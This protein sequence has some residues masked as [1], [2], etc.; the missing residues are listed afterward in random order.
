MKK[1]K[2]RY[3][4][5]TGMVSFM[6]IFSI[7]SLSI[8]YTDS[9]SMNVKADPPAG[10][11][12]RP[13]N[14]FFTSL[15]CGPCI[16]NGDPAQDEVWKDWGY[17][18]A[19]RY[20]WIVFHTDIP[21]QDDLYTS[22]GRQ[23][24]NDYNYGPTV[25]N[26]TVIYD[27]G[28]IEGNGYP[29]DESKGYIDDSG[30]RDVIRDI[31]VYIEQEFTTDGIE[32]TYQVHYL[33]GEGVTGD[34]TPTV[35]D[36]D[37][38]IYIFVVEDNVTAYSSIIG[39]N[40]LNHNVFRE[41]AREDEQVTMVED[42][43]YNSSVTWTWPS[44]E[45]TVPIQP[46]M[47][48]GIIGV[49]DREDTSSGQPAITMPRTSNSA[50]YK[51]TIWDWEED[52]PVFS[53]VQF[54]NRVSDS[55]ISADI[56]DND[57]ISS[58][59]LVYNLTGS[60]YNWNVLEMDV[61]S[62][63]YASL[64]LTETE[65][66]IVNYTI[67]AYDNNQ[68]GSQTPMDLHE[69]VF[70][71]DTSAPSVITDLA[72]DSGSN[73]GEVELTWS[74]PGD[75]G[76]SGTATRYIIK[77]ATTAITSESQW[78]SATTIANSISPK[79]SGNTETLTVGELPPGQTYYFAVRAEDEVGNLALMSNS[80]FAT[81]TSDPGDITAPVKITNLEA[82][83]GQNVGEIVLTWT[84]PG[85]DGDQGTASKYYIKH[86]T[87]EI[88]SETDWDSATDIANAPTPQSASNQESFTINGLTVDQTYYFAVR[89]EDDIPNLSD[90]S[91]SP[92]SVPYTGDLT[93]PGRIV[94]LT[95]EP[96]DNIGEVHLSWTAPNEDGDSGGK[97]TEYIIRYS[98]SKIE[99][100]SDWD[101]AYDIPDEPNPANPGILESFTITDLTAD[102]GYYFAIRS[103]DEVPNLSEIS[104]SA[105]ATAQSS[106][107]EPPEI[108]N[109]Y[110][111][112]NDPTPSDEITIYGTVTGDVNSVKLS[113][114]KV[115]ETCS[116]Q[117]MDSIGSSKYM[118]T[119][120]PLSE[121]DYEYE[122]VARDTKDQE[123]ISEVIHLTVMFSSNEDSDGDGVPDSE[124]AFPD[125]D[126]Q[127]ED[128]DNDGYGD[129]PDGNNPDA[130]P[131]D[132]DR[133]ITPKTEEDTP[134]YESD[135]AMF[136]IFLLIVVIVV[137]ALI[138]GMFLARGKR[139]EIPTA[140]PVSFDIDPGFVPMAPSEST[141]TPL[142]AEPVFTPMAAA[143]PQT[144]EIACPSC[145]TLFDIPTEPRPLMV[146]C[147]SCGMQ[148]MID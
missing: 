110:H 119:L 142:T 14:E 18:P 100:E 111:E 56:S 22:E 43:W 145:S 136:M 61:D 131:N 37:A 28:Y 9:I 15:E 63:G 95:A 92:S 4:L 87:I 112:P 72:A 57:G 7:F 86:S 121:G 138:A 1:T 116:V 19:V 127:W 117:M 30:T 60:D 128:S 84:A 76:S 147:P 39:G 66:S 53:N 71:D 91:N 24:Q 47:V 88:I 16:D 74:A 104:N 102:I 148:G 115:N 85:D 123:H 17:D 98:Q 144:E 5:V 89:A 141:Y 146:S 38:S 130:F 139:R 64:A 41:Y 94:D 10:Y 137:C 68:L 34:S 129:N 29:A 35:D 69:I 113:I 80:P 49:F 97:A 36:I 109:I 55:L 54:T 23:R 124:D 105:F 70:S 108:T 48:M 51:S 3:Y 40:Y 27:G 11:N 44:P 20:N 32:F 8:I 42:E 73:E 62:G 31:E 78:S 134:W 26:P 126:S 79:S 135:S 133:W 140:Q 52:V 33:G 99:S 132:P 46:H 83:P 143:L 103:E 81:V 67:L 13:T 77:Y 25:S 93:E 21:S 96:G 90:I 118:T 75:D 58:A 6:M 12:H 125:D 107:F 120:D 2:T 82:Q 122:I 106:Q 101:L 45:P 114:C 50:N 65:G 59:W